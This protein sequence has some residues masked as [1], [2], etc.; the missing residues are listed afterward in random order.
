MTTAVRQKP[1]LC[2]A[3]CRQRCRRHWT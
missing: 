2:L 1:T 3:R